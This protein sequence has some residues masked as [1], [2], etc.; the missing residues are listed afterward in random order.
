MSYQRIPPEQPYPP[1]GK[2]RPGILGLSHTHLLPMSDVYPPLHPPHG[3]SVYPPPQPQGPH[4][5]PPSG[6]QGYFNQGYRP[7][8]PPP[9]LPPPSPRYGTH[10]DH[11]RHR[12]HGDEGSNSGFLKGCLAALCC[13]RLLEEC[14][15]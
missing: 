4:Y 3:P 10:H 12:R 14:C 9:Q 2:S 5:Q 11:C 1:P 6:Y 7:Y 13:C 8:Y 15:F